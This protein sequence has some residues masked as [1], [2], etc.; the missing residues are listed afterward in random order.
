MHPLVT[1][2]HPGLCPI[3]SMPLVRLSGT[4]KQAKSEASLPLTIPLTAVPDTGLRKIVYVEKGKG[5]YLPVEVVTGPRADDGYPVLS[6]LREGDRVVVR[7]NFLL[8]SQSQIRG[9]PSLFYPEG[10]QGASGHRHDEVSPSGSD[11]QE[12]A[13]PEDHSR[14]GG[15][16]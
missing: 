15:Q 1:L 9:L 8:D 13:L 11:P 5:R 12:P 14:H 2:P 6:G 16:P 10:Q 4:A 7:G 3:C